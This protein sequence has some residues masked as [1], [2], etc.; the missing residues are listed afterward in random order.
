MA[1]R[2]QTKTD[3]GWNATRFGVSCCP[4]RPSASERRGFWAPKP[5]PG[6]D[7]T[8]MWKWAVLLAVTACGGATAAAPLDAGEDATTPDAAQDGSVLPDGGADTNERDAAE[9]DA[10]RVDSDAGDARTTTLCPKS[11]PQ[12]GAPCTRELLYCEYGTSNDPLCNTAY[13]CQGQRWSLDYDGVDCRFSGTNDPACPA[14]YG[15]L[16][17]DGSCN[18]SSVCEYPEGRCECVLGCGHDAGPDSGSHWL[19]GSAS[20]PG[21]PSPRGA[22]KLGSACTTPGVSCW[23]GVCC[24]GASQQCGDAGIWEGMIVKVPCP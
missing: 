19:C 5:R 14:T 24:P 11:A 9:A 8:T 6:D 1:T 22:N 13:R 12:E 4:R 7:M 10:A 15:D 3:L 18:G 23:Y 17:Q 16:K 20:S 2:L 21:C